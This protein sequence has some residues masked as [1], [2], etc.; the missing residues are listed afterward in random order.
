MRFMV[1]LFEFAKVMYQ[2]EVIHCAI[3][4]M[5]LINSVISAKIQDIRDL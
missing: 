1:L 3:W 4:I 5:A 2:I